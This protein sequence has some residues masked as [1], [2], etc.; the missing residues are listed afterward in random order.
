[1]NELVAFKDLIK[2]SVLNDSSVNALN[3]SDIFV[4]LGVTLLIGLLFFIYIERLFKEFYIHRRLMF[5]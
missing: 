3:S 4:N 1:M 2:K 5:R